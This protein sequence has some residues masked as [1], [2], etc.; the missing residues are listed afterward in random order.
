[1]SAARQLLRQKVA[2]ITFIL[3][4]NPLFNGNPLLPAQF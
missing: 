2:C 4:R 1:L 3:M